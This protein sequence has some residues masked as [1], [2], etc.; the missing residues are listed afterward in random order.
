MDWELKPARDIG[1]P[2]RQRMRSLKR[3]LGFVAT[4][5]HWCWRL[6]VRLYLRLF[7][8]FKAV[9]TE[10][11]P[12]PPLI[13]IANHCSHLDTLALS[14]ILPGKLIDRV[15]PI[16]A[17][18]TFFTS[19][20]ASTFSAFAINAL[21]LRR[22][23]V[24]SDDLTLLRTRLVEEGL[25]YILFPEGTRSRDGIMA[26]FK[27]GIGALVAGTGVPVVPCLLDGT[28]D[29]LPPQ[30]RWPRPTPLRVRIGIPLAFADVPNDRDGWALVATRC[31]AAVRE[32]GNGVVPS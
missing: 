23:T 22:R 21:P 32:I 10:R 19:A 29:A 14:S 13:L 6:A 15:H 3:E 27:P 11:I 8:R 26:R 25:V 20:L 24:R 7:H 31:E 30:K 2:L 9:G 1:L 12:E 28:F 16:A 17:G 5:T 4:F 18:D